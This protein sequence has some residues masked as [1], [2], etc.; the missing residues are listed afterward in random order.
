MRRRRKSGQPSITL[1]EESTKLVHAHGSSAHFKERP[2][3]IADHMMEKAAPLDRQE[4]TAS[5]F[6]EFATVNEA[7]GTRIVF[8]CFRKTCEIM[9][10]G[11]QTGGRRHALNI[12]RIRVMKIFSSEMRRED[13]AQVHLISVG[14]GNRITPGVKSV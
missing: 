10:A 9:L 11:K 1:D 8:A 14:L 4:E 3:H 13:R 6:P 5:S 7:D 12:D 2:G